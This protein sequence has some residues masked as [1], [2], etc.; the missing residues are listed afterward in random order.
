[1]LSALF[2]ENLCNLRLLEFHT[3]RSNAI[4][5]NDMS[6]FQ[7]LVQSR[8]VQRICTLL[9]LL[10]VIALE[11]LLSAPVHAAEPVIISATVRADGL[12]CS[13]CHRSVY[14][15]LKKLPFVEKLSP[16]LDETSLDIQFVRGSTIVLERIEEAIQD[17]GFSLGMMNVVVEFPAPATLPTTLRTNEYF[18]LGGAQIHVLQ[19]R[20]V[21]GRVEL[22]LVPEKIHT[23]VNTS[24]NTSIN[25]SE[26]GAEGT[27]RETISQHKTGAESS[28]TVSSE[29]A[30]IGGKRVYAWKI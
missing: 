22:H 12:T 3:I 14:K 20:S 24:V 28:P 19:E 1:M 9:L 30:R 4:R 7:I 21:S 8:F 29:A 5:S 11:I 13:L 25:M 16:N 2:V 26:A 18:P 17:A 15:A 6:P 10:H 27:A 23:V